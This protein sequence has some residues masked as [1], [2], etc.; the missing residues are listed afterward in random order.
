M[1]NQMKKLKIVAAQINSLV[2]DIEGN[3]EKIIA[4]IKKIN[5]EHHADIMAF[6]ELAITGYPPEDLLYRPNL[7]IRTQ[8]ALNKI[9]ASVTDQTVIV[10]FP[11]SENGQRFNKA[12]VIQNG[13]VIREYAKQCLPN[14]TVFDE[15]RYFSPGNSPCVFNVKGV[16]VGVIVCED[17]WEPEPIA[18][19]KAAGADIIISINASPFA[20]DKSHARRNLLAKRSKENDVPIIYVNNIGGQDELV[21]DGGSLVF[22]RHGQQCQQA[23][24]FQEDLLITEIDSENPFDVLTKEPLKAEPL[25]EYKIYQAI[26][27]GTRDYVDKNNF[28]GVLLGLSGGIDSALTLAIAVDAFGPERVKAVMMP[29]RFTSNMSL[30]DAKSQAEKSGVE[31]SVIE[32][33]SVM[34]AYLTVLK[35]DFAAAPIDT[36]EE[37]LQSRI[38]GSLLMALSNKSG[39][40]V[41]TTGNKSEMAVGYSTLYGDMVGGFALLKDVYKTTVYR[42][43]RY[44]NAL[45]CVIPERVIDRP[46]SAELAPNQKDQDTLP[47]YPILDEILERYIARDESP[48][49]IAKAGFAKETV[50]KVVRMINRNEYKR[51]Q[52]P[53]GIRITERAFGKDRRYPITSG[54]IRDL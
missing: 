24:Y 23:N 40:M 43:A 39:Y 44:R 20:L 21:F 53:V 42:L 17:L 37:N 35:K 11:S 33:E 6:P 28:P 12:A 41:L 1:V 38:R 27:L 4:L 54:Y 31:Y 7:Y 14:Y 34:Q 19:S 36:T 2:G 30:E 47:P 48:D 25:D 18:Q 15:K 29:S 26:M 3:T 13:K 10:G 32:I 16:N 50:I 52:A 49:E 22:N 45:S 51:H 46:P 8:I 5:Q 9:A